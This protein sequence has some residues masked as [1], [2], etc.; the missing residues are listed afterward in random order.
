MKKDLYITHVEAFGGLLRTWAQGDEEL[1]ERLKR[2]IEQISLVLDMNHVTSPV[3]Q[4]RDAKLCL[5]KVRNNEFF[6]VKILSLDKL[7]QLNT[8]P[9]FL[10]DYGNTLNVRLKSLRLIDTPDSMYPSIT[11]VPFMASPFHIAEVQA[12][13]TLWP[14]RTLDFIKHTLVDKTFRCDILDGKQVKNI[15]QIYLNLEPSETFSSILIS[16]GLARHIDLPVQE[17]L[18]QDLSQSQRALMDLNPVYNPLVSTGVIGVTTAPPGQPHTA[19]LPS[20]VTVLLDTLLTYTAA[21]TPAAATSI[22]PFSQMTNPTIPQFI[23]INFTPGSRHS[24]YISYVE[25]GVFDFAVQLKVDADKFLPELLLDI[26]KS[27][28]PTSIQGVLI[29][30][31][32]CLARYTYDQVICRAVIT[33]VTED[34]VKVY[35]VDF[36]NWEYLPPSEVFEIPQRFLTQRAMATRF[37]LADVGDDPVW[38]LKA[39]QEYFYELAK[40]RKFVMYVKAKEASSLMQ[41]CDLYYDGYNIRHLLKKKLYQNVPPPQ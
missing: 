10:V 23:S 39:V 29:P 33:D 41:Y 22:T 6:R 4:L 13:D 18:I 38:K 5:L 25:Y 11:E 36:G 40:E 30:G 2:D 35:Y 24:V 7:E 8:V 3:Q 31:T 1:S 32:Q 15:I 20:D 9:V 37:S 12:P 16:E 21:C 27:F 28:K 17:A 26:H 34:Q 19:T 14:P